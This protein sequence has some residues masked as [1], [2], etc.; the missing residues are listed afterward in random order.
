MRRKDPL[1]Q[2]EDL[3]RRRLIQERGQIFE[4]EA[5]ADRLVAWLVGMGT[6]GL[7]LFVAQHG[8]LTFLGPESKSLV[9]F[10]LAL[11]VTAGVVFR[12]LHYRLQGLT[13][14]LLLQFDFFLSV[15]GS[16]LP[17]R[18]PEGTSTGAAIEIF[19][20]EFGLDLAW[21]TEFVPTPSFWALLYE[22]LAASWRENRSRGVE[23]LY[24]EVT[25]LH[26]DDP[27]DPQ[28]VEKAREKIDRVPRLTL[29]TG[30]AARI[31]YSVAYSAFVLAVLTFAG[32]FAAD[33][34]IVTTQ[35]PP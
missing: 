10:F 26:G 25:R 8:S 3:Y 16:S 6:A 12:L 23:Y 4:R 11:T 28:A 17:D 7:A 2:L 9:L 34:L 32:A 29:R 21:A 35:P 1:D 18:L 30:R 27:S 22:D 13:D 33:L 14:N 31:A 15:E 20:R 5:Q 24:R 19:K